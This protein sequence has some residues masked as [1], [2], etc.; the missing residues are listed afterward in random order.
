MCSFFS[1][2]ADKAPRHHELYIKTHTPNTPILSVVATKNSGES[3]MTMQEKQKADVTVVT[4]LQ[5]ELLT[6]KYCEGNNYQLCRNNRKWY[7]KDVTEATVLQPELLTNRERCG[8]SGAAMSG[9]Y[10]TYYIHCVITTKY[11]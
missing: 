11:W 5:P 4:P 10:T 1:R 3:I 8:I 7:I 6:N 9:N 2:P